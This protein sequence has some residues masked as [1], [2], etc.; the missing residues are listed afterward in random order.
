MVAFRA[1]RVFVKTV[2]ADAARQ[3]FLAL[4][5]DGVSDPFFETDTKLNSSTEWDS[6]VLSDADVDDGPR[7]L[8]EVLLNEGDD[9]ADRLLK[10]LSFWSRGN[11]DDRT[12]AV[13]LPRELTGTFGRGCSVDDPSAKGEP[14]HKASGVWNRCMQMFR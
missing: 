13:L 7:S 10:W 8:K 14:D 12:L 5:T 9:A 3:G 6:F 11:H 1:E 4:M 2:C